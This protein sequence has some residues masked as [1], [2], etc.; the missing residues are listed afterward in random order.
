MKVNTE[1]NDNCIQI[2]LHNIDIDILTMLLSEYFFAVSM[3][4]GHPHSELFPSFLLLSS[5]FSFI[6]PEKT[7]S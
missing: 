1:S 4:N 7:H 5:F 3:F 2:D 6:A